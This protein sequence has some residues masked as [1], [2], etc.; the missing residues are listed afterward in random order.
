ML[1]PRGLADRGVAAAFMGPWSTE[2][3]R[4]QVRPMSRKSLVA[5]VRIGGVSRV[6]AKGRECKSADFEPRCFLAR[7]VLG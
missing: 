4:A 5:N 1:W 6:P 7:L 3:P 2:G